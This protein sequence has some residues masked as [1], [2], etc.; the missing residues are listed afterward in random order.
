VRRSGALLQR[1]LG[2]GVADG[3]QYLAQRG[4]GSRRSKA[5]RSANSAQRRLP[6][7][8]VLVEVVVLDGAVAA[9]SW[10]PHQSRRVHLMQVGGCGRPPCTHAC[11]R[12]HGRR[13][14]RAQVSQDA[15][16]MNALDQR[17]PCRQAMQRTRACR[18]RTQ[19]AGQ[20]WLGSPPLNRQPRCRDVGCRKVGSKGK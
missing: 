11:A 1:L 16:P 20:G 7:S 18:L 3:K 14:A 13:R 6:Q 15:C 19:S 9:Q 2:S 12:Q 5:I 8:L 17:K 4:G 10:Q